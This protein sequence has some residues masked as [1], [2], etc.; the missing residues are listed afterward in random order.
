LL[1]S[2]HPAATNDNVAAPNQIP[3]NRPSIRIVA[4]L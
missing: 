4:I 3:Q 1:A 2:E